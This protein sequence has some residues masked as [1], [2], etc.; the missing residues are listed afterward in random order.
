[1]A[2]QLLEVAREHMA[3]LQAWSPKFQLLERLLRFCQHA[4]ERLVLFSENLYT[5]AAVAEL[6]KVLPCLTKISYRI[7]GLW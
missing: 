6:L 7:S 4:N 3:E 2:Q 5:Q 1:M